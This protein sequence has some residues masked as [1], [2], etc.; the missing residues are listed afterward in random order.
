MFTHFNTNQ[1]LDIYF[2]PFNHHVF[3]I[4]LKK[5]T[6]IKGEKGGEVYALVAYGADNKHVPH[7]TALEPKFF[8]HISAHLCIFCT[9]AVY[10][11]LS[12]IMVRFLIFSLLPYVEHVFL[13]V[14]TYVVLIK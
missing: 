10:V 2:L 14:R 3:F 6:K 11:R 7:F 12:L 5:I 9:G 8:H 13:H 4:D 1:K